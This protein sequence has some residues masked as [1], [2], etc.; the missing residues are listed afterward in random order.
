MGP[1][2]PCEQALLCIRIS[3]AQARK[4]TEWLEGQVLG[5]LDRAKRIEEREA[6]ITPTVYLMRGKGLAYTELLKLLEGVVNK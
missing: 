4:M 5:K 2:D 3:K 1:V 6:T